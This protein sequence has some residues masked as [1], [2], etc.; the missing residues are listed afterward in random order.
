MVFRSV[1]YHDP[2]SKVSN[3]TFQITL[4]NHYHMSFTFQQ[5]FLSFTSWCIETLSCRVHSSLLC[6]A[7]SPFL[8]PQREATDGS[9]PKSVQ[10][11][12][13]S[14]ALIHP[15]INLQYCNLSIQFLYNSNN[16]NCVA[17]C[18]IY[19]ECQENHSYRLDWCFNEARVALFQILFFLVFPASGKF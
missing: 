7:N 3:R 4:N 17:N 8:S 1:I 11:S 9:L 16:S 19:F 18:S 14:W 5:P 2:Q 10:F 12:P 6:V 15:F 13:G